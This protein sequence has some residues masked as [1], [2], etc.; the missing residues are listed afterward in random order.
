MSVSASY[1]GFVEHNLPQDEGEFTLYL[2]AVAFAEQGWPTAS[3]LDSGKV[4]VKAAS[5]QEIHRFVYSLLDVVMAEPVLVIC[6]V[7]QPFSG[8]Y[9][10]AI[11]QVSAES[12]L[13]CFD[14]STIY[15][16]SKTRQNA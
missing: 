1:S 15:R 4:G 16:C 12:R 3:K 5:I 9:I 14:E 10:Q 11:Q 13:E 8:S 6:L 7:E 2:A